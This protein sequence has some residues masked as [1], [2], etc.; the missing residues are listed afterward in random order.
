MDGIL[1]GKVILISGGTKGVGRGVAIESARQGAMV[2]IG[3]RDGAAAEE[4][5]KIIRDDRHGEAIFVQTEVTRIDGCEK[6]V[7]ETEKKYHRID[8]FYNY[9]GILPAASLVDTEES[10][11]DAVFDLNVKAAFF[12][13][14]FVVRVMLRQKSGSLVFMGSAHG[15]GGEPDRASYAVSKGALLTLSKHIAKNYAKHNIR[16]NWVTM[17][18]VATP[19]ELAFRKTQ[20]R[21]LSWLQREAPAN[22]PMG[23]LLTVEDHVPGVIYLLSDASSKVTGTELHITGGFTA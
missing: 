20:G 6:L 19:G 12:C 14:K 5:L 17:G 10:M 22:I 3:G 16:S 11:F 18:W 8:G 1:K 21:D 2:A 7:S 4:I 13:S 9:A 15:Y 23:S